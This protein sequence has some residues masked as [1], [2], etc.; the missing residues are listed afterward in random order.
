MEW[1]PIETAPKGN[2]KTVNIK[3]GVREL[4]EPEYILA[5]T[6]DGRVTMT[7]WVPHAERWTMFSKKNP[8]KHWMP[9][10]KPPNFLDESSNSL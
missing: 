1:Q 9:L 5:P 4:Y 2:Y 6:S 7:Y 8:P 10:P 3:N